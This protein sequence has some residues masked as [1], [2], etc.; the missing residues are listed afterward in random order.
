M[1]QKL[2]TGSC[3]GP[4]LRY[5]GRSGSKSWRRSS[6]AASVCAQSVLW[7]TPRNAC[8]HMPSWPNTSSKAPWCISGVHISPSH[9]S[10][11]SLA[12]RSH[13]RPSLQTHTGCESGVRRPS[14]C[15]GMTNAP[16]TSQ[17]DSDIHSFLP[18]PYH[19]HL[20]L[21]FPPK[22]DTISKPRNLFLWLHL[23]PRHSWPRLHS[24]SYQSSPPG[25]QN[26]QSLHPRRTE[27]VHWMHLGSSRL[28]KVGATERRQLTL[29]GAAVTTVVKERCGLLWVQKD[30]TLG[31][32]HDG[33]RALA[34]A[35]LGQSSTLTSSFHY[36]FITISKT[37]VF[38]LG[39]RKCWNHNIFTFHLEF[40]WVFLKTEVGDLEGVG[41][42]RDICLLVSLTFSLFFLFSLSFLQIKLS[43]F[44]DTTLSPPLSLPNQFWPVFS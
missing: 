27:Q 32:I 23:C 44:T 38:F 18:L 34:K 16:P 11:S 35:E 14:P 12:R 26:T 40:L 6:E 30:Q 22:P 15:V 5:H 39:E 9:V 31:M 43:F 41:G 13:G 33:K 42:R 10:M 19:G 4:R 28:A 1:K 29:L 17:H 21:C 3:S 24:N 37:I 25:F 20:L 2:A 7:S 8:H 36:V